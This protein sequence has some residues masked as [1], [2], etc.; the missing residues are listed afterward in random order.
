MTLR[1]LRAALLAILFA[2]PASP[3]CALCREAAKSQSDEAI[4]A[5]NAGILALGAPPAVI[6]GALAWALW[7]SDRRRQN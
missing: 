2:L 5:L 4:A 6:L 3:R 7:R 1:L